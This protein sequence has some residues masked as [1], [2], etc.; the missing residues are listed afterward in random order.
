TKSRRRNRR[1]D[2][3]RRAC[4]AQNDYDLP[5]TTGAGIPLDS[6]HAHGKARSLLP[7]TSPPPVASRVCALGIRLACERR[8]AQRDVQRRED[9]GRR[10]V[11]DLRV[12]GGRERQRERSGAAAGHVGS[13]EQLEGETQ[14]LQG[15]GGVDASRTRRTCWRADCG[16]ARGEY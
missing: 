10:A 14:L 9:D 3:G 6:A 15:P 5:G 12:R 1:G 11:V 2:A 8:I 16:G 13:A 7:S 4:L